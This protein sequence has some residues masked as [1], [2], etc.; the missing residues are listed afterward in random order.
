M[1]G[2]T[3][4]ARQEAERLVAT[5]LA[6]AQNGKPDDRSDTRKAVA[7]GLGALG[8]S[9]G[10]AVAG[11]IGQFTG[12]GSP[13]GSTAPAG[14][15]P[16]APGAADG[17]ASSGGGDTGGARSGG[18]GSDGARSGGAGPGGARSGGAGSGGAGSGGAGS[19]GAGSGGPSSRGA[20]SGGV[21]WGGA[22]N[23]RAAA[24]HLFAGWSTGGAECCVCPICKAIAA[25][26]DPSPGTAVRLATGAGDVATG[27]ASVLRGL[28]ALSGSRPAPVRPAKAAK[29]VFDP[30]VSWSAATRTTEPPA[31]EAA[32]P[33]P[34]TSDPWT[35][36]T[37]TA[38][39]V[40]PAAGPELI[41]E[42]GRLDVTERLDG[43]ERLDE[44]GR[45]GGNGRTGGESVVVAPPPGGDPWA[46]A[47]ASPARTLR[48]GAARSP[49]G[50]SVPESG[51]GSRSGG[52]QQDTAPGTT[53]ART[54]DGVEDLDVGRAGA[55][56]GVDHDV[57]GPAAG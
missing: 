29:P 30:D 21:G 25:V 39:P 35:A 50:G 52:V 6:M 26:R 17:T 7:D 47:V 13:P 48:K 46:A 42:P 33:D 24:G 18:T 16:D 14:S 15:E 34:A 3:G 27:V 8:D 1:T 11:L 37:R 43:T 9:L 49:V 19:G 23:A 38:P 12:S 20:G 10:D 2:S 51:T 5:I 31:A 53:A 41:D 40:R 56:D 28:S 4:S 44:P 36:A 54:D 55:G 57:P 32:D 22:S 45:L